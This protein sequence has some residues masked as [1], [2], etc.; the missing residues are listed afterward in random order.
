MLPRREAGVEF[1]SGFDLEKSRERRKR[2]ASG[3]REAAER[4]RKKINEERGSSAEDVVAV[5]LEDA[6]F[7]RD[8][9]S[10]CTF[11][12]RRSLGARNLFDASWNISSGRVLGTWLVFA[13]NATLA[14][15]LTFSPIRDMRSCAL[16]TLLSPI[17]RHVKSI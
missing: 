5:R 4:E 6:D 2:K 13:E 9:L 8:E 15:N 7:T 1:V 17:A 11:A 16:L 10:L 14:K 12:G 3:K